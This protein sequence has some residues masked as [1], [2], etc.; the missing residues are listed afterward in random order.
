MV[1]N[2][3]HKKEKD[4][5][6]IRKGGL[7]LCVHKVVKENLNGCCCTHAP[8]ISHLWSHPHVQIWNH[9]VSKRTGNTF[10]EYETS[11]K[12]IVHVCVGDVTMTPP[13][14]M[15]N[16]RSDLSGF[17]CTTSSVQKDIPLT[18]PSCLKHN[19]LNITTSK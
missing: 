17:L 13:I 3:K 11:L 8:I 9:R 10:A 4:L 15:H 5:L 2:K 1:A 7:K 19:E 18:S 6:S 14:F 16:Q 12:A